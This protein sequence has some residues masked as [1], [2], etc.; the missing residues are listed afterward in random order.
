M[1]EVAQSVDTERAI[2]NDGSSLPAKATY[3]TV[4]GVAVA[5]FFCQVRKL[6]ANSRGKQSVWRQNQHSKFSISYV[7]LAIKTHVFR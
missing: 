2:S 1:G 7:A 6:M 5:G 4:T 3:S